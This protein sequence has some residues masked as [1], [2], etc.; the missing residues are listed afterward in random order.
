MKSLR[1]TALVWM[2]VLLAV[3]GAGAIVVSYIVVR[4]ETADFLDGQLRQIALNAGDG[5]PESAGPP[6]KHDPED[7]FAIE[8]WDA[9]GARLR[10]TPADVLL[11][12]QANRGFT[13]LTA[14]GEDWR[15]Y[16]SSDGRRTV[17]VGQRMAV[18]REQAQG[19]AIRAATP[20]LLLIPLAWLVIGWSLG[21]M[22]GRLT[23]LAQAIAGRTAE[24]KEPIATAGAPAE[25]LP[26]VE[27]MNVLIDRLQRALDQQQRFVADA[28]HELRTP[29]AALQIQ[30]DNLLAVTSGHAADAAASELGAGVRRASALVDQLLK[31]ARLDAPRRPAQTET[32]DLAL[33]VTECV[34]DHMA[35]AAAKG[36]DLGFNVLDAISIS[37]APADLKI[38]FGNLIDNAVR[39]TS[40]GGMVDV[41]VRN[42][43]TGAL[44]EV[45][46]TGA[47]VDESDLPRLSDRFFRAAP[48]DVAGTGLGLAIVKAVAKRHGLTVTLANRLD[49]SGFAARVVFPTLH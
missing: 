18:R 29:L 40:K 31:M 43:A 32:I 4:D 11:P 33:F 46:D 17:Q 16:L 38:L 24:S 34:G 28:A 1:R 42:A 2:T 19:A 36:V 22:L 21:R 14:A 23:D 7:D 9:S 25:V 39:Y 3:V 5:L 48:P 12:R 6:V 20:I 41:S 26:L 10:S 49:R 13:T 37:G 47:G 44:V 8:I 15:V 27:A 30:I 45:I 35:I